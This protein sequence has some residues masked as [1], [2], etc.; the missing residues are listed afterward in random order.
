LALSTKMKKSTLILGLSALL[1]AG[2]GG[3]NKLDTVRNFQDC[4][5]DYS[6]DNDLRCVADPESEL[7][8][9]VNSV[10]EVK[11]ELNYIA[12]FGD[13]EDQGGIPVKYILSGSG[14][15]FK[16]NYLL[17]ADHV[18]TAEKTVYLFTLQG[19]VRLEL[20]SS[21]SYILYDGEEYDLER[22]V[23][24]KDIGF[25]YAWMKVKGLPEEAP[26]ADFNFGTNYDLRQ[27]DFTY[28][29]GNLAGLGIN[30][31]SGEVS[32]IKLGDRESELK[33]N[34]FV[35]SNPSGPGNSG[36][37]VFGVRD[38]RFEIL[39]V[40]DLGYM[41]ENN[42]TYITKIDEILDDALMRLYTE[43]LYQKHPILSDILLRVY[44]KE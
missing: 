43:D 25:D 33:N 18:V 26:I 4:C 39:G 41:L 15:L 22:V 1:G 38:G 7:E 21:R 10:Y 11:T 36:C 27:G 29:I 31:T 44:D 20:Q 8:K 16:G 40:L 2:C 3:Y 17:T 24:N 32:R 14:T 35:I 5:S 12:H 23:S 28:V 37:P 30:V 34:Y 9:M 19:T 6:Y 13:I 42:I